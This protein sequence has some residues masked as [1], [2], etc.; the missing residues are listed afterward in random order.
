MPLVNGKFIVE[1][2]YFTEHEIEQ[3][4]DDLTFKSMDGKR[5]G[6]GEG[7]TVCLLKESGDFLVVPRLYAYYT[8]PKHILDAAKNEVVDGV[9][10][11]IGFNEQKQQSRPELKSRQDK[12]IQNWLDAVNKQETPFKGGFIQAPCGC[13]KTLMALKIASILKVSTLVIAHKEFLLDQFRQT[14]KDFLLDVSEEDIGFVRQDVCDYQGKKIVLGMMQSLAMRDYDAEFYNYFGLVI[15]DEAHRTSAPLLSQ[16]V[17]KF[18]AKYRLALS[19]TPRRMDGLQGV[20]EL[21]LGKVLSIMPKGESLKPIIY[22]VVRSCWLPEKRYKWGKKVLL[23]RL[24]NAL[25]DMD[26]R[27]AWLV[28]EMIRALNKNRRVLVFS[29]RR[30]HL[31]VLKHILNEAMPTVTTGFYWGGLKKEELVQAATSDCIFSTY[32][33]GKE[34]LD[35]PICDTLFL[36]TPKTDVEQMIGRI[37]RFHDEKK[38]P[39]VVDVVDDIGLCQLFAEK[40]QK[41]Y[42]ALGYEVKVIK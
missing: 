41:Q 24:I 39:V 29:D 2:H 25:T 36:T 21:N 32:A 42:I 3:F 37:L 31:E 26:A 27:N 38:P 6:F 11:S 17:P 4:R 1:N 33:M 35:I 20:F 34:G 14:I 18:N 40:R 8:F 15:V 7:E 16:S 28:G 9:P 13:G 30:E 10:I 5:Y 12:T 22:Q 23:A 19:A